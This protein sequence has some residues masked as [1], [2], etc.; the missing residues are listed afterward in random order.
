MPVLD[1]YFTCDNKNISFEQAFRMMIYDDGN[2]NPVINLNPL[3]SVLDPYFTCDNE[4]ISFE[5]L[6]KLLTV[7]DSNGNPVL[8]IATS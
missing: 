8:N 5:Q 4:N 7:Q 6:L 1:P 2:G 3:G